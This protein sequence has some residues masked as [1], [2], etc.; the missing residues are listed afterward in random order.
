MYVR[1]LRCVVRA[2]V[3]GGELSARTVQDNLS[4]REGRA[5]EM[6]VYQTDDDNG[7]PYHTA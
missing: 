3:C 5:I 2:S 6:S 4:T 1:A 7:S